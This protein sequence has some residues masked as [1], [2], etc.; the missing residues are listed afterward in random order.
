[1]VLFSFVF[2]S[3]FSLV[4]A[5]YPLVAFRARTFSLSFAFLLA[6]RLFGLS[7]CYYSPATGLHGEPFFFFPTPL[8]DLFLLILFTSRS[9]ELTECCSGALPTHQLLVIVVLLIWKLPA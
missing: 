7:I 4:V 2:L 3:R 6:S 5:I 1:M 8:V 9:S